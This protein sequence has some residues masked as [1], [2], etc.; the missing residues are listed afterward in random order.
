[1]LLQKHIRTSRDEV[2]N[3]TLHTMQ[4]AR[5]KRPLALIQ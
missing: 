1:V 5:Q 3:I 2:K 4:N